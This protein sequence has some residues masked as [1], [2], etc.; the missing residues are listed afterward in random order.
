MTHRQMEKQVNPTAYQ[1][2]IEVAERALGALE[3]G[4]VNQVYLG[5]GEIAYLHRLIRDLRAALANL[6][7]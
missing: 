3:I 4:P 6:E 2:L 1:E 7:H 5:M